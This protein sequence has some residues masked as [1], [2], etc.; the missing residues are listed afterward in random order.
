[1]TILIKN[2]NAGDITIPDL[3]LYYIALAIKT[4][5]YWHKKRYED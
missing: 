3:N 1:M 4:V 2:S 5:W